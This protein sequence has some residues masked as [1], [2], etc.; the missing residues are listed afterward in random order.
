MSDEKDAALGKYTRLKE[1]IADLRE[2]RHKV[3]K[4]ICSYLQRID[5]D[6]GGTYADYDAH[7]LDMVMVS[8]NVSNLELMSRIHAINLVA[9][10]ANKPKYR[11]TKI[12]SQS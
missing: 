1:E 12:I 6:I 4:S 3:I 8:L 10:L 11:V 7:E 9:E 5:A 2:K